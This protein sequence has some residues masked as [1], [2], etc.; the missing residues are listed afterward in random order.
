MRNLAVN[1][2]LGLAIGDAL[3]VPVEFY[4]RKN[5]VAEPLMYFR[6]Y[7]AHHTALGEWSDD[8]AMTV[9]TMDSIIRCR[10]VDY[11]DIMQNFCKWAFLNEFS[12][13]G[14][15][16][17]FGR[18]CLSALG[19]YK[20]GGAAATEC[21]GTRAREN[22]NGA[23]MRMLPGVLY[24]FYRDIGEHEARQVIDRLSSLTHRH[25]ISRLGCWIYTKFL[26]SIIQNQNIEIAY[27]EV[28]NSDYSDFSKESIQEYA[29]ILRGD[30]QALSE[31]R[32][33]SSGYVVDTLEA[34]LW[35]L[36]N[37]DS[38]SSAVL[39][40]INLGGDTDTIGAI[41]G[42]I[43]GA[44]YEVPQVYREKVMRRD[45]LEDLAKQFALILAEYRR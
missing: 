35:S 27:H 13:S 24:C 5:L 19:R 30:L 23:L 10:E 9:A 43:A 21:G 31:D 8:T 41:T 36:L 38:F 42:S 34:S 26:L 16:F 15:S 28:Q 20:R 32:I 25:E 6:E 3:G 1:T 45:Y 2:L 33:S 7:G 40:A 37:S 44:I 4:P 22:G 39:T 14:K 29:R 11:E 18:T 17:G 12:A